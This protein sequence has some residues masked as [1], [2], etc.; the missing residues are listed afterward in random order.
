MSQKDFLERIVMN[1]E[2]AEIPYMISG[3]LGSSFHG[4]PRATNDIDIVIAPAATQLNIFIQSLGDDYY[5]SQETAMEALEK[6]SMFNIIDYK[7]AWKADIIIR[8]E[9]PFSLE[10]FKRKIPVNILGLQVYVVS[11]EDAILSKLEWAGERES[12][13]Q[14]RDALGVVIVQ[15]ENLNRE[16][17]QKW[18][19][20]LGVESILNTILNNAENLQFPD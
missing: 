6:H 4:E 7:T 3:S 8:K 14:F 18:A 5:I 12:E 15:W 17:L 9:R 13:L 20:E 2:N 1:L 11:P 10:E 16:Y 19:R